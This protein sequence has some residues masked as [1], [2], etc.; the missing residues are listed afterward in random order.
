MGHFSAE[1]CAPP[2]SALSE[3]QHMGI[4]PR[5]WDCLAAC[6]CAYRNFQAQRP[7]MTPLAARLA[8]I[9]ARPETLDVRNSKRPR[10]NDKA[11]EAHGA[12]IYR[13][14]KGRTELLLTRAFWRTHF[15]DR[16]QVVSAEAFR[17]LNCGKGSRG[18][19]QRR[20]RAG[21]GREWFVCFKLP[22]ELIPQAR[23]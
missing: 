5:G 7:A 20:I 4:L 2:G 10:L 17:L 6:V 14:V 1:I 19:G 13:G 23:S 16:R 11:F 21:K 8:T 3:N 22:S 12:F 9:L 15:P 18:E